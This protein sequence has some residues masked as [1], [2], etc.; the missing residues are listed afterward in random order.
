MPTSPESSA[1]ARLAR[2]LVDLTGSLSGTSPRQDVTDQVVGRQS[3][4]EHALTETVMVCQGAFTKPVTLSVIMGSP[5]SPSLIAA[6]SK[7]AQNLDGFQVVA[8]EGPTHDCWDQGVVVHTSA[9][10]TDARWPRL[11]AQLRGAPV[12]SV[13][14]API[15]RHGER[16]GAL[17]VYSVYD[18]LV[19]PATLEVAELLAVAV[20]GVLHDANERH[21]LE[22]A[23]LQLETA[24][25]SRAVIDQAKGI[26]MARHHCDADQ[27]FKLLAETSSSANVKLRVVAERLVRE[28]AEGPDDDRRLR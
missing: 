16:T 27:A 6:G 13:I 12:C 5:T 18:D 26:I 11:S 4:S 9:L 22:A 8:G 25:E 7:V 28:A 14:S 19:D 17:N 23:A 3:M 24:L 2:A 20:A 21:K 1:G 10:P 15:A